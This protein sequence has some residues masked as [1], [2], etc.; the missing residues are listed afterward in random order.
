M[1]L[2]RFIAQRFLPSRGEEGFAA[3]LSRAAVATI[4]LGVA[5]MVMAVAIL[6]GFQENIA[7]KVVGFGSHITIHSYDAG[8]AFEE[9]PLEYDSAL[10]AA[11]RSVR[12]VRHVQCY[13]SKGGMV[14]TDQQIYGILFRGLDAGYDTTFYHNCLVD[15]RLPAFGEKP[16]ND[17][18]ISST[19]AGKLQ[20]RCGDKMRTYFWQDNNYRSR[21]FTV[22]GIYNTDLTEMDEVY[23]VGDLRQV[24]RLNDWTDGRFV[25]GY[26]V[27]VDDFDQLDRIADEV[28][29]LLPYDMMLQTV[30]GAHPALFSWLDLLNTNIT[31]IL[32]IMCLVCAIAVISA[33]LIMIFEKGK[34]IGILKTLGAT[35]AAI[36]RIFMLRAGRL[37]LWGVA[38][39]DAVALTLCVVQRLTGVVRLDPESYSM[40]QVPVDINLWIVLAISVVTAAVCTLAMLLPA[41]AIARI[42]PAMTVKD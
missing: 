4:A 1:Q 31:L 9:S 24:Q 6:R 16:S 25:G 12:G 7:E 34:T 14:K 27:L 26:E 38:I 30:V 3:S 40:S 28:T 22:S 32:G 41:S 18:L 8:M 23:V 36:R 21:A 13:A 15:G 19:I 35:N 11:I 17:V 29:L 2:E 39:G 10:V 33:L 20:L 5:V 42:S 37:I